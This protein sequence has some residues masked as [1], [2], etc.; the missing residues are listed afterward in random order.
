MPTYHPIT[1]RFIRRTANGSAERNPR[2]DDILTIHKLGENNLRVVY[3]EQTVDGIM[4]DTALMT[5]QK[6]THYLMRIFWML[7]IDEDPFQSVQFYI[8]GYP[9]I[10][11]K[12]CTV[13]NNLPVLM[14]I[15]INTCWHWPVVARAATTEPIGMIPTEVPPPPP[16]PQ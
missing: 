16:A 10:L 12:V 14:D 5:Y 15:I 8:P 9:Q 13:Q 4:R 3:V 1:V 2:L 11:I 6:L 7:A